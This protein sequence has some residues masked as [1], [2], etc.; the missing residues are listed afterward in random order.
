MELHA[1]SA[2]PERRPKRTAEQRAATAERFS[3]HLPDPAKTVRVGDDDLAAMK[4][5]FIGRFDEQ[6][7]RTETLMAVAHIGYRMAVRD[8]AS[9][10]EAGTATDSEAGVAE[11]ETPNPNE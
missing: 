9:A 8:F 4:A 3:A 5:A 1:I 10:G 2:W 7:P 11:G 6:L